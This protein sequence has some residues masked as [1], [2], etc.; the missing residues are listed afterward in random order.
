[1]SD[2]DITDQNDTTEA[3]KNEAATSTPTPEAN[4]KPTKA[5]KAPKPKAKPTK[6]KAKAVA[7]PKGKAKKEPKERAKKEGLRLMQIR[8]L[9]ALNATDDP[10]TMK[11]MAKKA[12]ISVPVLAR[13]VG[14]LD[15]TKVAAHEKE[16]GFRSLVGLKMV[17]VEEHEG[18]KAFVIT[19]AGSKAIEAALKEVKSLPKVHAAPHSVNPPKKAKAKAK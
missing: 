9:R 19:A 13:G 8:A 2:T 15:P 7:K 16:H 14:P 1:M 3:E 12:G 4:G 6:P 18:I 5:K 17:R 11:A 10:M